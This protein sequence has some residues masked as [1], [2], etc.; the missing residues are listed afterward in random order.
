M[1]DYMNKNFVKCTK[2]N[3]NNSNRNDAEQK[4][5]IGFKVK[6]YNKTMTH[7]PVKR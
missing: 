6:K 4:V 1:Q 7:C 3:W 2:K 5:K